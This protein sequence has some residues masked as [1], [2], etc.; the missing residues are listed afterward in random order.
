MEKVKIGEKNYFI[1][2]SM[3]TKFYTC[4]KCGND[5]IMK[6]FFYCPNCGVELIWEDKIEGVK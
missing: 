2:Y 3:Y 1:T 4:P 5:Y 6:R